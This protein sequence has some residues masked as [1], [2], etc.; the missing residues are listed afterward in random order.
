[1]YRNGQGGEGLRCQ[2]RCVVMGVEGTDPA[3]RLREGCGESTCP[4]HWVFRFLRR[5]GRSGWRAWPA[6]LRAT[7]LELG[8]PSLPQNS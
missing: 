7:N 2:A 1:M 8:P 6:E 5:V 4:K 3:E